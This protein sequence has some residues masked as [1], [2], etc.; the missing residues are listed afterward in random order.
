MNI[1]P[2]AAILI[3]AAIL[4]ACGKK[5][6]ETPPVANVTAGD[7]QV[8]NIMNE[9]CWNNTVYILNGTA[10]EWLEQYG[11]PAY[12]PNGTII[13]IVLPEKTASPDSVKLTDS[14]IREDG[15][16]KYD[17]RAAVTEIK[18]DINENVISFAL[19]GYM[20]SSLSSSLADYENGAVLRCFELTC[21]WGDNECIY[22]FCIRTDASVPLND[23]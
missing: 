21:K 4:T 17:E 2:L 5:V 18:P 8:A 22:T 15:S 19:D 6:P 1:K 14:I 13:K 20:A 23:K 10:E 12:Y 9:S 11:V 16:L 3:S 7:L